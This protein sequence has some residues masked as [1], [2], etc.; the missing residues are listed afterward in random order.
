MKQNLFDILASEYETWFVENKVFFQSELL[1]LKQVV[2]IDKTGLE[3]GIGS[4]IFAKP[5]G[6]RYGIDPSEKM[7]QYARQR[8]LDVQKGVAEDLPYQNKSFDFAVFITAICFV[9]NPEQAVQEAHRILKSRGEIIIAILDKETRFGRFL[10]KEKKK[11]MFYKYARF[12]TVSEISELL[13]NNNFRVTQ[14]Y[15]TLENP[16]SRKIEQPVEGNGKGSFVVIKGNK[17]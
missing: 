16:A 1:A 5:L 15:Q 10:E 7:L 13:E 17:F 11:S 8:G 12:F 2:P 3:I 14:I 9:D 4:G 6:I